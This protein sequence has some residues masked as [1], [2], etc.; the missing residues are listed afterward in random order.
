MVEYQI[1][2]DRT[3][4]FLSGSNHFGQVQIIKI[5]P[6]K[7]DLNQTKIIWTRPERFGS[8][9]NNLYQ[10]KTIWTVQNNFAL[11]EGQGISK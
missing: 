7:Y 2:L 4:L 11:I 5:S 6:E 3:N 1:V 9:Q 10:S 8:D